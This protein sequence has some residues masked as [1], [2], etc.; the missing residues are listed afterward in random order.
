MC[1]IKHE[2]EKLEEIFLLRFP[3][4]TSFQFRVIYFVHKIGDLAKGPTPISLRQFLNVL[5][6][7]KESELNKVNISAMLTLVL[8]DY[9]M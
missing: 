7:N 9:F 2:I 3:L 4:F 6:P 1:S 5:S 8:I